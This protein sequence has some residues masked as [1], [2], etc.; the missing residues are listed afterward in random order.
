[1]IKSIVAPWE[2]RFQVTVEQSNDLYGDLCG[3]REVVCA[4]LKTSLKSW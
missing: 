2:E 1:M 4:L 3:G